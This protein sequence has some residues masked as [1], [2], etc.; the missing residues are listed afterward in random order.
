ME[1]KAQAAIRIAAASSDG[2]TIDRHF[3]HADVFS[4][5]ETVADGASFTEIER[6]QV[7]PPCQHGH[8]E[9]DAMQAVV[10]AL[11]DCRYVLAEAI[12]RVAAAHLAASGIT[13]LETEDTMTIAEAVQDVIAYERRQAKR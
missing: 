13:P 11:G 10:A 4:I 1:R 12:G 5:W 3:G 7:S 2:V 8:H 9:A 6:R